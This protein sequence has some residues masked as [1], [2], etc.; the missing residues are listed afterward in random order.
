[1]T[2][3]FESYRYEIQHGDDADFVAYQRKS[4]DGAWQTISSW[5]IPEPADH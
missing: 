4:S 3:P 5:M 2:R 1:M